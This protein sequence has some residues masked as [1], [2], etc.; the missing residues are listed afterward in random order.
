M[1]I[2]AALCSTAFTACNSD[3]DEETTTAKVSE[4]QYSFNLNEDILSVA[5]V[6]I[7]YIGTDGEEKSEALTST[8]WS[9]TFTADKFNVS[10]G[11]ALSMKLKSGIELT[12][13]SYDLKYTY[14]FSATSK[15]NGSEVQNVGASLNKGLTVEADRV[16]AA[17]KFINMKKALKTDNQGLISNAT[18]SW[19]DNSFETGDFAE[20]YEWLKYYGI[21]EKSLEDA[22]VGDYYALDGK[23]YDGSLSFC[24]VNGCLPVI[25]IV[26][27]AG[28]NEEDSSKY[29]NNMKVHGYAVLCG[30]DNVDCLV[31]CLWGLDGLA[32]GEH[33]WNGYDNTIKMLDNF[34]E[35]FTED[36][37]WQEWNAAYRVRNFTTDLWGA[38]LYGAPKESSGFFIPTCAQLMEVLSIKEVVMK[39]SNSGIRFYT[40]S[41]YGTS[42][43]FEDADVIY[44]VCIQRKGL[45]DYFITEEDFPVNLYY[46]QG[47]ADVGGLWNILPIIAF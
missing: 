46:Q 37:E 24:D 5:D 29:P 47:N 27:H 6:T 38:G 16:E 45:K 39:L 28:K 23:L 42:S 30:Y 35:N 21:K 15:E 8:S 20:A 13:E 33:T 18:L 1:A 26:F 31:G 36:S 11:I 9:K 22:A 34:T 4:F 14:T 40:G 41:Y 17:L 44:A 32:E 10:A 25:G 3:D 2:I 7:K 19:Q 43:K 12:K